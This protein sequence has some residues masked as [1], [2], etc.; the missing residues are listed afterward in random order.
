MNGSCEIKM[1]AFVC[2]VKVTAYLGIIVLVIHCTGWILISVMFACSVISADLVLPQLEPHFF[3]TLG[4]K[5]RR[6][7]KIFEELDPIKSQGSSANSKRSEKLFL[8]YLSSFEMT[9]LESFQSHLISQEQ[10]LR[11]LRVG[12]RTPRLLIGSS[13][14]NILVILHNL[15]PKSQKN[16][17]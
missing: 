16:T 13:S 12:Q 8:R 4:N 10:L 5:L 6:I 1:S 9:W 14:S 17:A 15:F 7:T 3:A 11:S 2:T